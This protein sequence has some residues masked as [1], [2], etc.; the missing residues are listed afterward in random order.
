[1]IRS[2]KN[3]KD[4]GLSAVLGMVLNEYGGR[5]VLTPGSVRDFMGQCDGTRH[6]VDIKEDGA[7]QLVITSL[8]ELEDG[9]IDR[10]YIGVDYEKEYPKGCLS[11]LQ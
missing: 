9:R 8:H 1:V 2:A 6:Y 3:T 10:T 4:V 11:G 5:V 7:G